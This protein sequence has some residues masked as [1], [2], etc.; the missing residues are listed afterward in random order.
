VIHF[1]VHQNYIGLD[2]DKNPFIL[3]VCVT[4]E[5]NYGVPQY[6]TIL[7]KTMG[8]ERRCIPYEQGKTLSPKTILQ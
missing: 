2:V 6:R 4:E 7:W 3:S 1:L 8:S 5:D